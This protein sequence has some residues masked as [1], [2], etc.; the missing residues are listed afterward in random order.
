MDRDT[1]IEWYPI[2]KEPDDN[3]NPKFADK[4]EVRQNGNNQRWVGFQKQ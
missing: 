3:G 1:E 4:E 2:S